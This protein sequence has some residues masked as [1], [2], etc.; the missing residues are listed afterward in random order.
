M[1]GPPF[2]PRSCAPGTWQQRHRA[3]QHPQQALGSCSQPTPELWVTA[4]L[5]RP[6][7]E[8][9]VPRLPVPSPGHFG[10]LRAHGS[11]SGSGCRELPAVGKPLRAPRTP[12]S[13]FS[14]TGTG[15]LSGRDRAHGH[16]R[17]S[18][19]SPVL[20]QPPPARSRW[21]GTPPGMSAAPLD[22]PSPAPIPRASHL[23]LAPAACSQHPS[24]PGRCRATS[25]W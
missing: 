22:P 24:T 13:I 17:D 5:L 14:S 9:G 7:K 11:S 23:G 1:R 19:T 2:P 6:K 4:P 3:R 10:G 21:M 12:L 20:P 16:P 25:P 15:M 18:V 8:P